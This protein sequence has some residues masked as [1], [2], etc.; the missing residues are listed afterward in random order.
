MAMCALRRGKKVLAGTR[1]ATKSAE[2]N[3]ELVKAGGTWLEIDINNDSA[4]SI[5]SQACAQHGVDV[6]VNNAAMPLLGALED[7]TYVSPSPSPTLTAGA[8]SE[9]LL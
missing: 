3:P 5:V 8:G 1:N 9:T 6:L 4:T 2:K 7:M